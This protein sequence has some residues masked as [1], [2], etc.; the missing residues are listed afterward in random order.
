MNANKVSIIIVTYNSSEVIIGCLQSLAH[1][2][3][4]GFDV[5]IV[6]NDSTDETTKLI[7]NIIPHLEYTVNLIKSNVNTG[8]AGGCN[9]GLKHALG[10]FIALLNP[11]ARVEDKWLEELI[12]PMDIPGIGICA[13]K[14]FVAGQDAIDSAGDGF[15]S[16]LKGYKQGEGKTS[17][18]YNKPGYIFGACAGAALYRRKMI[19]EIGFMDEDF[20]LIYEDVDLSFRAQISGW[21]VYYVPTAIV[22]HQVRFSIGHNSDLAIY[23]SL[24]NSGYVRIKNIPLRI[25]IRCFPSYLLGTIGDIIYFALKYRKI[26]LY[27]KA[28]LAVLKNISTLLNKRKS[29]LNSRK[30]TDK[31]LLDLITPVFNKDFLSLK[32]NKLFK[33]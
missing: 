11:D 6:D 16:L 21:K 32:I 28:K 30:V 7:E 12:K 15:S 24:R 13:S 4:K 1:Q 25:F 5:I 20:F 29:I 17:S 19:D 8:F 31:Y 14:M 3:R 10:E 9:E 26:R 18:I 23:Y 33:L 27:V 2:V 22:N